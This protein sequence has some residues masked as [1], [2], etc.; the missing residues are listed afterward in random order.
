MKTHTFLNAIFRFFSISCIISLVYFIGFSQEKT[1]LK[2]LIIFGYIL[3]YGLVFFISNFVFN[4]LLSNIFPWTTEFRKRLIF[5]IIGTL[6]LN[7][8]ITL[9]TSY[10]VIILINK[11]DTNIFSTE[12]MKYNWA[13]LSIALL[14]AS[15]MH[16][17]GFM[18]V[19][20]KSN[21]EKLEAQQL[22]S[23]LKE[24]QIQSLKSQL[25][26]H[27]LFNALNVLSTLID[28]NPSLALH[29]TEQLSKIY[30]YVLEQKNNSLV[31]LT[32][33]VQFAKAYA[34]LIKTRLG[35]SIEFDFK[36]IASMDKEYS[37]IPLSLQ[38][39]LENAIK[40]NI[41]TQRQPL[42]ICI[43]QDGLYLCIKNN[44]QPKNATKHHTGFGLNS[45]KKRYAL[46]TKETVIINI[47]K[48]YFEVQIPLISIS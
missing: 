9:L 48:A 15:I 32:E 4:Y 23:E 22:V 45:I 34:H 19:L 38:L 8:M 30:R 44:L 7:L 47:T 1:A 33:E 20:Q 28:E 24:V 11:I 25:D 10:I 6:G 46:L 27:F 36:D 26:P 5:G 13:I 3:G 40:H 12:I 37:I 35:T 41:A 16:A 31:S 21:R 2:F 29:F 17:Y 42:K 43:Y 39:L 14:V 18:R